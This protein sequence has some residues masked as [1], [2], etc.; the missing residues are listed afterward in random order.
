MYTFGLPPKGYFNTLQRLRHPGARLVL[1]HSRD[2][3]N[4]G[5]FILPDGCRV[6]K[7]TAEV[8]IGGPDVQPYDQGLFPDQPQSWRL[9]LG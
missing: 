5:Y 7:A 2:P 3:S 1:V 8:I 6:A 9:G 4:D